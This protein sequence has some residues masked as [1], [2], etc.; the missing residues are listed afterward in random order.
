[1]R[2][3]GVFE[4]VEMLLQRFEDIFIKSL[5]FWGEGNFCYSSLDLLDFVDSVYMRCV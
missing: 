1:M 2:E 5:Y 3:T 4:G